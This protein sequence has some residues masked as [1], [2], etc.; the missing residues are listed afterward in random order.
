MAQIS[1]HWIMAGICGTLLVMGAIAYIE[2]FRGIEIVYQGKHQKN[3]EEISNASCFRLS[4]IL[5]SDYREY[6]DRNHERFFNDYPK[7]SRI[8]AQTHYDMK[9]VEELN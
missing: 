4:E 1:I 6:N 3:F 2:T 8:L 7:D 9:C 5:L